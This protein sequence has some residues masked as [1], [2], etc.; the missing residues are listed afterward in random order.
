MSAQKVIKKMAQ[1]NQRIHIYLGLY[2]LFFIWLFSLSGLLLNHPTWRIAQFWPDREQSSFEQVVHLNEEME[3][4]EMAKELML[5]LDISGEIERI[6]TEKD[7]QFQ[8]VKPGRI[9]SITVEPETRLATVEMIRVNAWG[10]L[11]M[12]HSFTGVRMENLEKQRDWIWTHIWSICIDAVAAGLV[13]LVISG[14]WMWCRTKA[15]KPIEFVSLITGT[16]IC[17]FFLFLGAF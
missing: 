14:L 15:K 9:Y 2:L 17:G 4:S 10:V 13:L 12:L 5:Q 7:F 8:V 1:W 16:V 6:V 3:D 11:H